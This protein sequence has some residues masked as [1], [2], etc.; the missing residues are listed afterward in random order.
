MRARAGR[1]R[2]GGQGALGHEVLVVMAEETGLPYRGQC[3]HQA[4]PARVTR[5]A[6]GLRVT[7]GPAGLG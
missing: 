3:L 5:S 1:G 2:G 7:D 4:R 6:R